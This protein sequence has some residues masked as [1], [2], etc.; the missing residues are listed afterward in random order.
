[1]TVNMIPA[2][3]VPI[4]PAVTLLFAY[5]KAVQSYIPAVIAVEFPNNE[6]PVVFAGIVPPVP[7]VK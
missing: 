6:F 1:M 7:T 2:A 4:N 5:L 3:Y